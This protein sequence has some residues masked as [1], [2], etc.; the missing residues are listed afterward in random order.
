MA[1]RISMG[2]KIMTRLLLANR[3]GKPLDV[4]NTY[5]I[6][7]LDARVRKG[8]PDFAAH[9]HAT[10]RSGLDG[11]EG[12]SSLVEHPLQSSHRGP[13]LCGE[14]QPN[15]EDCHGSEPQHDGHHDPQTELKLRRP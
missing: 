7:R 3:Q 8:P 1:K 4:R 6:T 5:V 14:A 10:G 15:Q 13:A 2:G 12:L 9:S 11:A